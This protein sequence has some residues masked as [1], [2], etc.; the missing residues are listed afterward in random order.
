MKIEDYLKI[1]VPKIGNAALDLIRD[2][3][4]KAI[5]ELLIEKNVATREEIDAEVDKQL[6]EIAKQISEMPPMPSKNEQSK[7]TNRD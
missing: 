5:E 2:A 4:F 7:E 1:T 6:G 3:R